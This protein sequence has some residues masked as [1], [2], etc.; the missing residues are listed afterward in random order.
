MPQFL[1][2]VFHAPGV[3]NSDAGAY[4][5]EA[6]MLRAFARTKAFN[7]RLRAADELVFAG[8]LTPPEEAVCVDG[9]GDR[10]VRQEGSYAVA[11]AYLGGFWVIEAA[12]LEE[13]LRW[14]GDASAACGARL[15]VRAF[16]G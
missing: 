2:S 9:T 6:E 4:A 14:A 7:D 15:E 16:Q 13:A 8:G 1:F 5:D 12:D 3:H 11:P 10:V